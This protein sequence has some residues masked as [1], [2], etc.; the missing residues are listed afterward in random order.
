MYYTYENM[1]GSISGYMQNK[2]TTLSRRGKSD[3]GEE[4]RDPCSIR[5]HLT[6]SR[7]PPFI[8]IYGI[9]QRQTTV[10][11]LLPPLLVTETLIVVNVRSFVSI[12]SPSP[13][14]KNFILYYII[15]KNII[16]RITF[17]DYIQH[18][19]INKKRNS[20]GMHLKIRFKRISNKPN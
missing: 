5:S 16:V 10:V 4:R 8:H 11:L 9:V 1:N 6:P 19:K 15:Q 18:E 3:A 2:K 12:F 7:P 13:T 14:L 20:I 17:H